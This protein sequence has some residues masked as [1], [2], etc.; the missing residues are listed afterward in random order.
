VI[1][2]WNKHYIRT[3]NYKII[4]DEPARDV[5]DFR[6]HAERLS[7]IIVGSKPRFTVGIFGGWGTG[8]TTMMQMINDQ[9]KKSYSDNVTTIWF[10]SW[11]YERE[12]YSLMIPLQR[13]IILSLHEVI[14]SKLIGNEKKKTLKRVQL[15]GMI[16]AVAA[17]AGVNLGAEAGTSGGKISA[18]LTLDFAKILDE[19]SSKGHVY[20]NQEKIYFHK[21]VSDYLKEELDWIK[22]TH[23]LVIFIDDLD[24]CTPDGALEIL[25][26]IK[27]F[28]IE[29]IIYV[30][31]MDPSTIDPIIQV[32]YGKS[33]KISGLD[34]KRMKPT[35]AQ[36]TT[37]YCYS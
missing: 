25:E 11:R 14:N 3:D 17:A 30:I 10:D 26:S 15:G 9:I 32:K 7:K 6:E 18:G 5:P 35:I 36:S 34:H 16:K 19:Y 4:I 27:T 2:N 1:N 24:R 20:V 8:K 12:E 13:T 33:P 28:D 22:N 37:K 21:H 29:G 31:G 23:K